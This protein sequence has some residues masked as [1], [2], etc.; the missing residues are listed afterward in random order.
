M[1][2]EHLADVIDELV[3]VSNRSWI[4]TLLQKFDREVTKAHLMMQQA[5]K[6]FEIV[7]TDCVNAICDV[8]SGQDKGNVDESTTIR[9]EGNDVQGQVTDNNAQHTTNEATRAPLL[10]DQVCNNKD[11]DV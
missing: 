11:H 8:L 10:C 7:H 6:H 3:S 5:H 2:K 1:L 4:N 9:D